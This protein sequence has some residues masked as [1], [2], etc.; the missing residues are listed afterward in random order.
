VFEER[1]N[2]YS[3]HTIV[4]VL[5]KGTGVRPEVKVEPE[6]RLIS[7]RDVLL[8]DFQ[9]RTFTIENISSFPVSF[10]LQS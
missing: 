6:D 2:L 10:N 3:E 7:F 8:G 4:S 5:L 9:E 1:I